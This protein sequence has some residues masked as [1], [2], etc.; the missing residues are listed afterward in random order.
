MGQYIVV[1]IPGALNE[2]GVGV[3][4]VVDTGGEATSKLAVARCADGPAAVAV[5]AALN[6]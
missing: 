3:Y 4:V 1:F 5:A 2:S 6:A